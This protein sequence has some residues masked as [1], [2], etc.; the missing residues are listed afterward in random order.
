[1]IKVFLAGLISMMVCLPAAAAKL[2]LEGD[3]IQGGLVVGR[4]DPGT[5]ITLDGRLIRVTGDGRFVFGFG[6][7]APKTSILQAVSPDGKR[8]VRPLTV[9]KRKYRISRIDGLPPKMVTPSP[10]ALLRIK[11]EA[12]AIRDARTIFTTVPHFAG[13]FVWPAKGRISG[14]YGSQRILNGKPR[15]PHLGLDIAAPVGT[16]VVASAPGT[17]TLANTDMYFTGG[18]VIID[19]GH[20]LSTVY[21]HLSAV[22]ARLGES[23][24]Q[25]Q[26]IGKLGS[27]GR[28]TGPHLDWRIN[29]FQER[30]DPRLL[31][32]P[33][34][35]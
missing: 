31:L 28:S 20:G 14:V 19:H 34:P 3:F 2:S 4:T 24:K 21:S 26:L 16:P 11:A 32:G 5:R 1:M 22:D 29:W 9:K 13:G 27:T 33:M 10:G 12:K 15:R 8:D 18:T 35:K 23:V 30:L 6:R 25:G 17:V 7:D